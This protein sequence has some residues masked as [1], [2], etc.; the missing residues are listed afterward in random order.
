MT[1]ISAYFEKTVFHLTGGVKKESLENLLK[2][3]SPNQPIRVL[4]Q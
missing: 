3:L 1:Y 4:A 2:F